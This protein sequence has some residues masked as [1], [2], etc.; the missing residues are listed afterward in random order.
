MLYSVFQKNM[1]QL[2]RHLVLGLLDIAQLVERSYAK[3]V[4]IGSIPIIFYKCK[5]LT[6]NGNNKLPNSSHFGE[7]RIHESR[8]LE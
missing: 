3:R 5:A 1:D 7:W 4:V 2:V 8:K 6:T